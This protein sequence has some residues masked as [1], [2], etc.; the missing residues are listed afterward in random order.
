MKDFYFQFK[1]KRKYLHGTDLFRNLESFF[2]SRFKSI[3]IKFH[4]QIN[5]QPKLIVLDKEILRNGS[6]NY[7]LTCNITSK[8]IINLAMLSTKIKIKNNYPFDESLMYDK[9]KVK[10][11]FAKCN[12]KTSI[13]DIDV[14]VA[15]NKFWHNKRFKKKG[16]QWFFSRIKLNKKLNNKE[17]KNITIKKKLVFYNST[18][19]SIYI[20]KILVGEIYFIYKND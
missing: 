14:I 6:K 3:D 7:L 19:S 5:T 1:G 20:S 15:L 11:D 8:N 17:N 4:R 2:P 9:F 16:G 18:V 10:K 13:D 12:F